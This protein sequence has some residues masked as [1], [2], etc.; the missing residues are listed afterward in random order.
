MPRPRRRDTPPPRP[1]SL[2]DWREPKHWDGRR[3]L[4]CRYC[5]TTTHLR[6]DDGQPA[7]KVCAEAAQTGH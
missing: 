2:L 1:G 3:A 6:D 7:H 4:P 5:G